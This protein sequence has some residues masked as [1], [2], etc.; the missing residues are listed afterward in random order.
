MEKHD[1]VIVGSG[2]GGLT[3][4]R[5]LA[6]RKDVLVLERKPEDRIG[7]KAHMGILTPPAMEMIPES[8]YDGVYMPRWIVEN[9]DHSKTPL[10]DDVNLL[11]YS[12]GVKAATV[13]FLKLVQ[14]QLKEAR[15]FGAEVR[16]YCY[17]EKIDRK[18]NKVILRDEE[19]IGYDYL[20]GADGF[21]SIVARSLGLKLNPS[22]MTITYDIDDLYPDLIFAN[23]WYKG[24]YN[25]IYVVPHKGHTI[26]GEWRSPILHDFSLMDKICGMWYEKY[27]IDLKGARK[28]GGF[29]STYYRGFKFGNIFLVGEAGGFCNSWAGLGMYQA[30]KS[31]KI[32][33][34]VIID[35]RYNYKK[36]LKELLKGVKYNLMAAYIGDTIW[37]RN[38]PFWS[39]LTAK[40][41][42]KWKTL[43]LDISL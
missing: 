43:I 7:D 24:I 42:K 39:K 40:M 2:P 31:A 16:D 12:S 26:V 38:S 27:G 28:R 19:E 9:L 17:V 29:Y 23:P 13:D 15:R 3:A 33:A 25:F 10:V 34:D 1:V 11:P 35:K 5:R 36:P 6:P 8:L 20:I 32:C 22:W 37:K 18:R 4:A 30:M 14:Y 41:F 21:H